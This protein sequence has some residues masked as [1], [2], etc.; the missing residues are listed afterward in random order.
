MSKKYHVDSER[1]ELLLKIQELEFA[2][3]ELNLFLDNFPQNQ[4]ALA[5]F[6]TFT[7]E[8][9]KLKKQFEAKY[10][11]LTNFGYAQSQAPWTWVNDPWPWEIGE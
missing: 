6:N 1:S 11:M 10:G 3:I 2:V 4:E 9:M 5:N 8:L 7:C